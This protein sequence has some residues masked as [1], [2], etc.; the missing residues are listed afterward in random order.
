M[1]QTPERCLDGRIALITGASRGI[2][3]AVARRFATEGAHLVLTARTRGGLEETDDAVQAVGGKATL[4]ELDLMDGAAIDQLGAAIAERFG[5]LDVL[6]GN[7]AMLGALSP[8]GHYSPDLWDRVIALN[9]TANWRLIRSM[10]ALLRAS[11]AGR[12]I[13]TTCAIATEPR[14]YWG[15][16][17]VSK[18]GLENLV[19]LYAAELK[20]T[21]LRVNCIDPGI[22]ETRL[23]ADAYPGEAPG[24]QA[25]PD[26]VTEMFVTLAAADCEFQ[27]ARV[28]AAGIGETAGTA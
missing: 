1:S 5:K 12:A 27:G 19:K 16:Y 3:A 7:A 10:D 8:M 14:A 18:A 24:T 22:V 26:E 17:G 13:F 11:D 4:V 20:R 21:N 6:V 28:T 9:L 23:R 2:G 25:S 15:P